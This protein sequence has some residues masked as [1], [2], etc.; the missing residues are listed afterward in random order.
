MCIL[1]VIRIRS[2]SRGMFDGRGRGGRVEADEL[3]GR[4]RWLYGGD[5]MRR[6]G[7]RGWKVEVGDG[8]DEVGD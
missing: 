8:C 4:D 1:F 5:E 3:L 2:I 6:M 7:I